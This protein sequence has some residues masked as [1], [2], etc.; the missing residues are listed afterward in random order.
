M[1]AP[2]EKIGALLDFEKADLSIAKTHNVKSKQLACRV[3][4]LDTKAEYDRDNICPCCSLP[5]GAPLF[6]LSCQI[7]DLSE[8][9]VGFPLFLYFAKSAIILSFLA[10]FIVGIPCAYSNIQANDSSPLSLKTASWYQSAFIPESSELP[11]WQTWL[12]GGFCFFMIL[13]MFIFKRFLKRKTQNFDFNHTTP[14]DFTVWVRDLPFNYKQIELKNFLLK[15]AVRGRQN[16]EISA[17]S[18]VYDIKFYVQ[19]VRKMEH[20]K[21]TLS[22]VEDYRKKF[23]KNP[24]NPCCK[25]GNFNIK[26]L[27][28]NISNIQ[29]WLDKFETVH[30]KVF[31]TSNSAFV[32]FKSQDI[33]KQCIK[34][35]KKSIL[36]HVSL[37]LFKPIL[38]CC[39][40]CFN[41][42]KFKGKV[43]SIT[44]APEPSDLIWENLSVKPFAKFYRRLFTIVC[45][46]GLLM[47]LC[48]VLFQV[49]TFQYKIHEKLNDGDISKMRVRSMSIMMGLIIIFVARVIAISVRV[50]SSIEKHFS[51]TGYHMAVANKLIFA[52]S[53]NSIAVL[54]VVN[55]IVPRQ[56]PVSIPGIDRNDNTVP[57]YK[58]YGLASDLFWLLCTD[59]VVSPLTY[60]LSPLY[61]AKLCKRRAVKNS[62]NR[63]IVSITQGEA[64][65]IWENPAV[66]MAQ[67]YA[68]Y[69]KTL[70]IIFV[71]APIFPVGLLIGS[72]S[73]F[74]Q[75]WTDKY[76]LLRRHARPPQLGSKISD[77]I[78][79]WMPILILSYAVIFIQLS[80]LVAYTLKS[81]KSTSFLHWIPYAVLALSAFF[82]I[83]P[84]K[85][86]FLRNSRKK[87]TYD[88]N[89]FEVQ[90]LNFVEDYLR[91]NPVTSRQGWKDWLDLIESKE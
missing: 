73:M 30:K 20:Y 34:N 44:R 74:L 24:P 69:M 71:F 26:R 16:V 63:G 49:K 91:C 81:E 10:F 50:F 83:F 70:M 90:N 59:A 13:Y 39:C 88:E 46:L 65:Q 87:V 21:G 66:D 38:C 45:T 54:L 23:K 75:Y 78:M 17:I 76:L 33:S 72:F 5:K 52:T 58:E 89:D 28:A 57:L 85:C 14:S 36:D 62:A 15:K 43:L 84:C 41:K 29:K 79:R 3:R 61:L 67:R 53:L 1:A 18:P 19:Q 42:W 37:F 2:N 25:S 68:N 86:W 35:W 31:S 48:F 4:R 56:F 40:C 55:L 9:G 47:L 8:L 77:N 7:S 27:K 22:Y 60:F 12:H 11:I 80:N 82:F 51:W 32:T 6:D 64:N